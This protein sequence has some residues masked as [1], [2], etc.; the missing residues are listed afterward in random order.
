MSGIMTFPP[1]SLALQLAELKRER[2]MRAQVYPHLIETRKLTK[3]KAAYHNNGLDGAI[4]TLERLVLAEGRGEPGRRE[5]IELITRL[6]D[7]LT[8]EGASWSNEGLDNLR[9][10][11]AKAVPLEQLPDWL[12]EYREV[13]Q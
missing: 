3:E 1:A 7:S 11:V 12:H 5:L 4:A 13:P 2:K 8:D 6:A 9:R 10:R